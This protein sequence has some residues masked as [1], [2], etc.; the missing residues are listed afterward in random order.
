LRKKII[1]KIS[2]VIAPTLIGGKNTPS[3]IDGKSLSS[4]KELSDIKAL[5]LTSVKKLKNSY[6]HL[7]YD[8]INDTKII[9]HS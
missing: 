1:D 5:K 3:L 6:I 2:I 9:R 4:I 7:K 8:V